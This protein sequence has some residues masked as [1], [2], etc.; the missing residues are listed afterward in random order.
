MRTAYYIS[1]GTAITSEVFGHALLSLFT[2]KFEHITIPFVETI[3]H[4]QQVVKKISE[5]FQDD[6][7]RPLV[8]YTIVN[9]D[10]RKVIA[11][12]VGINYNFLDQFVAPLEIVLGVPSKPEKHRTHSIHE[13]T[14]D[15]RI[16]AVN[17]ALANDDGSNLRDYDAADIIL[18]GVSRSGKTPTSLYLA[19]QY[20]IKAANYPF[21]EEDMGDVLKMPPALKRYKDKLFG[22]TIEVERLH[23]IRSERRANSRYAS[24]QQCRMELREVENLYR[25]EKIPFLNSTRY[26]IEEISAKI[27][28]TT[29]LKRKNY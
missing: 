16:E 11:K 21:T 13:K 25:K 9:T 28:A 12:S 24:M 18:V 27:L 14:Y 1:D 4:A 6:G 19:L 26:S 29:G 8:F 10:V 15:I 20:G 23:Q 5:S 2:I 7:Q 17:Y 3:E 22:L